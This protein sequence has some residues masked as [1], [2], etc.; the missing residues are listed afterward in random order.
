MKRKRCTA[1][2]IAE[3]VEVAA[4]LILSGGSFKD[5]T[6]ALADTYNVDK[7]TAARYYE[8]GKKALNLTEDQREENL[9]MQKQMAKRMIQKSFNEGRTNDFCRLVNTDQKI[10]KEIKET[11]PEK[12]K[13]DL[14]EVAP[15][16]IQAM[17]I[18][19]ALDLNTDGTFEG[20]FKF[21]NE[22]ED[23]RLKLVEE[24]EED[25]DQS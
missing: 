25:D 1:E 14:R 9:M 22:L 13:L 24:D 2:E 20:K 21:L 11:I 7:R 23:E 15:G 8:K 18:K 17:L 12:P 6:N 10:S 5:I 4:E 16:Q 3:R 19:E